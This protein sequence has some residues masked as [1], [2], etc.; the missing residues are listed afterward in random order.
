[1]T[2]R[3]KIK[4]NPKNGLKDRYRLSV[5]GYRLSVSGIGYQLSVVGCRLSV[6]EY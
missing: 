3:V 6:T 4:K 1:M 2:F 5:F